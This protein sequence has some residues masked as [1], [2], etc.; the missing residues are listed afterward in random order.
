MWQ[1]GANGEN[2][3][4]DLTTRPSLRRRNFGQADLKGAHCKDGVNLGGAYFRGADLS[5][6]WFSR[7]IL[8][9]ANLGETDLSKA[10]LIGANLSGARLNDANLW[11]SACKTFQLLGVNSVQ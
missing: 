8:S 9:E 10:N 11:K 6:A 4:R 1:A 3:A 7:A 5:W 2:A